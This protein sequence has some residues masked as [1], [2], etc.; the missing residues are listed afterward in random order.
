MQPRRLLSGLALAALLTG[1]VACGGDDS[2]DAAEPPAE[3]TEETE[4]SST[5]DT[6]APETTDDTDGSTSLD[7]IEVDA[8]VHHAGFVYTLSEASLDEDEF[9]GAVITVQ[10]G[11]E[12]TSESDA[13]PYPT[14]SIRLG[15]ED[16]VEVTGSYEFA[17][18]PGK[19]KSKGEFTF[20]LDEDQAAELDLSTAQLTIGSGSEARA[21][22]PLD[23]STDDLV[24]LAPEAQDFT[25]DIVAGAITISVSESEVR[26]DRPADR[27]QAEADTAFLV[28]RGTA[29]NSGTSYTCPENGLSLTLPDGVS[30]TPEHYDG[31]STC[32]NSG[33]T[34]RNVEI[35]FIIDDDED[36]GYAAELTLEAGGEGWGPDDTPAEA[37]PVTITLASPTTG[38]DDDS[39]S[40][41][42]AG[43]LGGDE[44]VDV[45]EVTDDIN[46]A[47]S[48]G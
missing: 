3:E 25:G 26:W 34:D 16:A 22:V 13:T 8:T 44:E 45:E 9:G 28:L 32:L 46:D 2:D 47:L 12:N 30:V 37:T 36:A 40:S 38:S 18:I 4:E 29:N 21:V 1:T 6:E 35:W 14:S 23:G 24:T 7:S 39:E 33:E 15:D 31:D 19:G 43:S 42:G 5:D 11:V 20:Q 10:A 17:E 41:D 48:G 27:A